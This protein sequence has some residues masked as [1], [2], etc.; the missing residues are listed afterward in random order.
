[1]F[2]FCVSF[3]ERSFFAPGGVIGEK[4]CVFYVRLNAKNDSGVGLLLLLFGSLQKQQCNKFP[5]FEKLCLSPIFV[6]GCKCS[7]MMCAH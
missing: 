3:T 7:R 4:A 5:P 6:L 1:M 2:L